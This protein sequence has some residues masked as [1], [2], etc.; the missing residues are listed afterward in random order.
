MIFSG[1]LSSAVLLKLSSL[2]IQNPMVFWVFESE[3]FVTIPNVD[4]ELGLYKGYVLKILLLY[5]GKN[6]KVYIVKSRIVS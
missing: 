4:D 1:T 6:R 3:S 5:D 2:A